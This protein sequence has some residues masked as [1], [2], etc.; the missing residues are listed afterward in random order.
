M[1]VSLSL[2]AYLVDTDA[3]SAQG[4]RPVLA[5]RG[6]HTLLGL[7]RQDPVASTVPW[8]GGGRSSC[9]TSGA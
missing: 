4:M 1:S 2:R 7:L 8:L 6:A 5:A 3:T 9:T